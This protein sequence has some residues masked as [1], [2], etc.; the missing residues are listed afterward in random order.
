MLEQL[1]AQLKIQEFL[2]SLAPAGVTVPAVDESMTPATDFSGGDDYDTMSLSAFF[3]LDALE[4]D[5]NDAN[6]EPTSKHDSEDESEDEEDDDDEE[7]EEG[8]GE[9]E[10]E[11]EERPRKRV[12]TSPDEGTPE[13]EEED[14]FLPIEDVP[15]PPVQPLDG[16]Y[17]QTMESLGVSS[18]SELNTIVTQL[19]TAANAGA[20]SAAEMDVLRS[21]I[22]VME[23]QGLGSVS[24]GSGSGS[25]GASGS[26]SGSGD[27]SGG[28]G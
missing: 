1:Q 5:P 3:N 6:F 26:G 23:E 21:L 2:Q 15:V 19:F 17:A 11:E 7:D 8:D 16:L 13:E 22:K 10:G 9:E 4:D 12:R 27:R 20:F 14:L 18:R 24:S 28:G 25:G